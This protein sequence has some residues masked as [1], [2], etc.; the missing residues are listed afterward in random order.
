MAS[1]ARRAV[2]FFGT[3]HARVDAVRREGADIMTPE[4]FPAFLAATCV[5][6]LIVGWNL[7]DRIQLAA[8]RLCARPLKLSF[9]CCASFSDLSFFSLSLFVSAQEQEHSE[10]YERDN[11][12]SLYD[13]R[14]TH[15]VQRRYTIASVKQVSDPRAHSLWASSVE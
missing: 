1:T 13:Y 2:R 4:R 6:G 7:M 12:R 5:T 8:V 15:S 14:R 9:R 10:K 11:G 3:V